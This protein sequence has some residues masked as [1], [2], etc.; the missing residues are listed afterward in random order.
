MVSS[1]CMPNMACIKQKCS[2]PC[3]GSCGINAKCT[4]VNH[5][6]L[7]SCP[8]KFVGDPFV[9]CAYERSKLS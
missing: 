1:D 5:N 6:A 4:V 8:E 3:I 9:N 7:C 2:D